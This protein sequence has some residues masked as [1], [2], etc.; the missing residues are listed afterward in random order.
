M[1]N[2]KVNS[3]AT[4][5]EALLK[6]LNDTYYKLH[7]TYEDA[8]WLY[9]MGDHS[10][11]KKMNA[12]E[13]ARDSFKEDPKLSMQ[14]G[15]ALAAKTTTKLQKEKLTL[16]K[17]F[18]DRNQVPA[19]VAPIKEKI[20]KLESLI[21]KQRALR[22]E[23]YIDP[24]TNKFVEA[25]THKMG[26]M[27]RAEA[28]ESIRRAIFVATEKLA[29]SN[30]ENFVKLVGLRNEYAR[31]LGFEDFYAY[32]IEIEEGMT[33]K[34]LFTIFNDIYDKTKY[35]F[36]EIRALEK[37]SKPGL[38]KPWN[39]AYMMAGSF[40][41]EEDLYFPF[42]DSILR[43]GSSFAAMGIDYKGGELTLDLLDR[44]GKYNNGFCH[45][46][47]LVK[48]EN[49]KRLPGSS[50]FTCNVVMGQVGTG[51]EG[52][53]TLFHEGGHAAHLLNSVQ[54]EVCV[55]H[56]YPPMSTAWAETHSMFLDTV[57]SSI[58][59]KMRY[60]KNSG[61]VAYPIDLFKRKVKELHI[62]NPLDLMGIISMC[63]FEK[64][65]YEDKAL[66]AAKAVKIAREVYTKYSD[67]SES[68]LRLLDVP[69]LY[70]W[71]SACSY[72]GYGLAEIAL[73]QWREYF[74]KKYG[75]IVDNPKVGEEMTRVWKLGASKTFAE[76]IKMATGKKLTAKAYI[77]N[78]TASVPSI[79]K[80]A[81]VRIERLEKVKPFMKKIN[82]NAKISMVDGKNKIADNSRGFEEMTEKYKNWVLK[83]KQEVA[84]QK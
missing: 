13:K 76:M 7:K 43:W 30:T 78:I 42:E 27:M 61:G 29:A 36:K 58:E 45:W 77:A 3:A 41:K 53:N 19:E 18:F 63:E 71:G 40:T 15:E 84:N 44:K 80:R 70:A 83:K 60:A 11:E 22:K 68:A 4:N 56:E 32:K 5:P 75:Y 39:F 82:L 1:K 74:Y 14:V 67:K 79:L 52:I 6:Y 59:W 25:S 2:F 72:H 54:T 69:H 55:N 81:K 49:G 51:L 9:Y 23:G 24:K 62:L 31:T 12:A 73:A 50:N 16:W 48:Y 66:T 21:H 47:K 26:A 28:D 10:V 34:E 46:P 37:M 17:N 38:R 20:V 33:K 65:I 57:L 35:A 64:R 8:F